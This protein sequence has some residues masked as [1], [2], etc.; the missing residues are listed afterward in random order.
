MVRIV[1]LFFM[2]CLCVPALAQ[3]PAGF[4]GVVKVKPQVREQWLQETQVA[5]RSQTAGVE[6]T[7]RYPE[8]DR[9]RYAYAKRPP[10]ELEQFF[11]VKTQSKEA[12]QAALDS[13]R[14]LPGVLYAEPL[15]SYRPLYVPN[16]PGTDPAN[17]PNY[18]YY[19][20][21]TKAFDAWDI[22]Q[23]NPSVVIAIVD[24]GFR[25]SHEDLQNN[26]H[27]A[28]Y[29]V[30]NDDTDLTGIYHGT[31]VAGVSSATPDNA[32]G[33]AGTGFHCRYLPIKAIS[34]DFTY[35]NFDGALLYAASQGASVINMSFGRPITPTEP[36]S[37][38]ERDILRLMVDYYDIVLVAAGGNSGK[39]EKWSPA[40]YP[41]VIAVSGTDANDKKWGSWD[42]GS[43]FGYHMDV[44]APAHAI[45]STYSRNDSDYYPAT[46]ISGTSF[47][48]PQVSAAAGL[49]RAHFP[50]LNAYQ[51][52][53]RL[54]ATADNIDA[55]NPD[56]EGKLGKGRLNIYRALAETNVFAMRPSDPL[57]YALGDNRY[58]IHMEHTN[59]LVLATN[60]QIRINSLSPYVNVVAGTVNLGDFSTLETKPLPW[61]ALVV[62][63][64]ADIPSSHT[65]YIEIEYVSDQGLFR[66]YVELR[67]A[68]VYPALMDS[69]ISF[70]YSTAGHLAVYDYPYSRGMRINDTTYVRA[71]GFMMATSQ[72]SVWSTVPDYAGSVNNDFQELSSWSSVAAMYTFLQP[73]NTADYGLTARLY[74]DSL[75]PGVVFQEYRVHNHRLLP[76]TVRV[77]V[78]Y[79]F[80]LPDSLNKCVVDSLLPMIYAYDG[81]GHYM[82]VALL[83]AFR[84]VDT[85]FYAFDIDG[86]NGSIAL[87]DGFSDVEMWNSMESSRLQAGG[88]YADIAALE[89][90]HLSIP[91][92]DSAWVAWAVLAAPS[93]D[94]LRSL[95]VAAQERFLVLRSCMPAQVPALVEAHQTDAVHLASITPG[96]GDYFNFYRADSSLYQSGAGMLYLVNEFPSEATFFVENASYDF[97]HLLPGK[98][99]QM[100]I[101]GI[102]EEPTTTEAREVPKISIYPNPSGGEVRVDVQKGG[103]LPETAEWRLYT[104]EGRM[105]K[106]GELQTANSFYLRNLPRGLYILQLSLGE[107]NYHFRLLV[108]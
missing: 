94:S 18:Q 30:G 21:K 48:A 97:E 88:N 90:V 62:E 71:A 54:M 45:Y 37:E 16:D 74:L 81:K 73:S 75:V 102:A 101:A 56:F 99:Q 6:V 84:Q 79:D 66:E 33:I 57:M 43:T 77:G 39:D 47:A 14:R 42:S 80:D 86:S 32:K 105:L 8:K 29:D 12:L 91:A 23:G 22:E 89:A 13:L 70:W 9:Q 52:M 25:L 68:P 98:W 27:P 3:Q 5:R 50:E 67:F 20:E 60:V 53:A 104:C 87:N 41:E 28:Y 63:R 95:Y 1:I 34:D 4:Y 17:A 59:L 55:Q 103:T 64:A 58:A 106:K 7:P 51:V 11:T 93:P 31:T 65:A 36:E 26:L 69:Q 44:A 100:T 72:D 96:G 24:Y 2:A 85:V 61:G 19:L 35:F 108:E 38:F 76:D 15:Y 78:F 49:L 82:A 92:Q 107:E 10:A 83:H 40:V 46:G